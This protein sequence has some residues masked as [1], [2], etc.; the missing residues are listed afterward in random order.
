MKR[1]DDTLE[2]FKKLRQVDEG[3]RESRK[4]KHLI[5][6]SG[7]SGASIKFFLDHPDTLVLERAPKLGGL[8][9]LEK[10]FDCSINVAG[11]NSLRISESTELLMKAV[12][13]R[14]GREFEIV[15]ETPETVPDFSAVWLG[16]RLVDFPAQLNL[17]QLPIRT[18]LCCLVEAV[19]RAFSKSDPTQNFREW[20][21]SRVGKTVAEKIILPHSFKTYQVDPALLDP[22]SISDKVV[23]PSL[24]QTFK[25]LFGKVEKSHREESTQSNKFYPMKSLAPIVQAMLSKSAGQVWNGAT[26]PDEGIDFRNKVVTLANGIQLEY[27][28]LYSTIPLPGL[29]DL[30]KE[31]SEDITL[32]KR[33]LD[34]NIMCETVLALE[35]DCPIEIRKLWVPDETFN[36]QR[37]MFPKN[38][39]P[40]SCPDGRYVIIAESCYPK[41]KKPL[42]YHPLFRKSIIDRTIRDLER[43]KI[44]NTNKILAGKTFFV[45]PAY[46][47]PDQNCMANRLTLLNFLEEAGIQPCGYFAEWKTR[48]IDSGIR[49]AWEVAGCPD[50]IITEYLLEQKEK[51]S[52]RDSG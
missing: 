34:F 38:I 27:E 8:S 26:V 35:G 3:V 47:I 46:I 15:L 4:V 13:R 18:R 25:A 31:P 17:Y 44:F 23:S 28:H 45:N 49:R 21:I 19:F 1:N 41:G 50:R 7:L 52:E 6:G 42:V 9:K 10:V 14:L 11:V 5:I 32:A 51:E 33:Y 20:V 2:L 48:D 30:L 37:L 22:R 43:M 24:W 36:F 29:I 40:D 39:N 12:F 16:K